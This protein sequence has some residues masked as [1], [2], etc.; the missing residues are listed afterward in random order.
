[1]RRF[2]IYNKFQKRVTIFTND[3]NLIKY[4]K[5]H[6]FFDL[7]YIIFKNNKLEG[8][9]FITKRKSII[10]SIKKMINEWKRKM[11]KLPFKR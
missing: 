11:Y 1:M 9:A 5:S 10:E 2:Y 4:L 6:N 7:F 3:K 8:V